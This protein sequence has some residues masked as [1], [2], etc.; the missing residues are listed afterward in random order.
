MRKTGKS[1]MMLVSMCMILLFAV[2]VSFAQEEGTKTETKKPITLG[3]VTLKENVTAEINDL[4]MIPSGNG[5]L[6]GFTL[7]VTNNSNAEL[8]FIDYWVTLHTKSGA[9]LTVNKE[10]K[11]RLTVQGKSTKEIFYYAKASSNIKITDL[12]IKMNKWDPTAASYTK[13]LG[14][15]TVPQR[16]NP[17]TSKDNGRV[18]IVG[19]TKASIIINQATIGKSDKFYR[20]DIDLTIKNEGSSSLTL[21]DYLMYI[22]T[23][24]NLLYPV[25]ANNLK[26]TTLDPLT[27]KKFDLTASIPIA[28]K[29]GTWNLVVTV[30]V[31]EGKDKM[32]IAQLEL[33]KSNTTVGNDLNKYYTFTNAD[34]VYYIKLNSLNRLPIEDND[35]I[36]ANLTLANKGTETIPVPALAGTYLFN[37]SI[38]KNVT[39]TNNGK[40]I[41]IPP[42]ST[43]DLQ[44]SGTV[45]YTFD[46]AKANLIIQQKDSVSSEVTDLVEF[47]HAGTFNPVPSVNLESGFEIKDVG[48]RSKVN[49]KEFMVFDGETA[50]IAAAQIEITNQEKRLA[51]MQQL[52][53]YFEKEDGTVYSATFQTITDKLTPGGNAL[54]YAWTTVP[55]AVDTAGMKLVIGKAVVEKSSDAETTI[56]TGYVTP[57]AFKLPDEKPAQDK[58]QNIAMDPYQLSINRVSTSFVATQSGDI[59]IYLDFDYNLKQDM[60][61]RANTKD[62]RLVVE[63]VDA[64]QKANYSKEF[65]L[66]SIS[67]TK[68]S[69]SSETNL[70]LGDNTIKV[71]W[72]DREFDTRVNTLKDYTLNVYHEIQPGYKKLIASQ[73]LPWL[74]NRTLQ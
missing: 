22:Q 6:I 36:V 43:V 15:I 56:V 8:D 28:V 39:V 9:K 12:L 49:V 67:N 50:K 70:R 34:G 10:D 73:K 42:G 16:Y 41:A 19:E 65:T 40:V 46:I 7:H 5:Q 54:L 21:P 63:L 27:E 3:K 66:N 37:G 59:T 26:G 32:P 35:L 14:E 71:N 62:Q 13:V 2:N 31:N 60:L 64:N 74:V 69:D 11:S 58:L 55:Q 23:N 45:P 24:E 25:T 48:Y 29:E 51:E 17:V 47:T 72:S 18:I 57:N 68:D 38:K 30:P 61:T 20:P 53:G 44:L 52:A 33:P 1:M 4:M